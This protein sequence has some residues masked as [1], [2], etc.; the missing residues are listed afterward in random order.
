[1]HFKQKKICF[2]C[3]FYFGHDEGIW[4]ER[5]RSF[6]FFPSFSGLGNSRSRKIKFFFIVPLNAP[7]IMPPKLLRFI[8]FMDVR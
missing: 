8:K 6:S 3:C 5:R 2:V 1:M 7:I 4:P